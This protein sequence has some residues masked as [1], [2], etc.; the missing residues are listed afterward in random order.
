L[1]WFNFPYDPFFDKPLETDSEFKSL[2]VMTKGLKET[3]SGFVSQIHKIPHLCLIAGERGVGKST[4]MYYAGE[5]LRK[6]G[7]LSVYIG[8]HHTK[9]DA[10][11]KPVDEL[12]RD[13][14]EIISVETIRSLSSQFP[15]TFQ[16]NRRRYVDLMGFLGFTF[17]PSVGFLP[18]ITP[19]HLSYPDLEKH[20][21]ELIQFLNTH[22]GMRILLMIDNLDKVKKIESVQ[23][24]LGSAFGQTFF[25]HLRQ[26]GAS[27]MIAVGPRFLA[28]QKLDRDLNY[29]SRVIDIPCLIP[30]QAFNLIE[31]RITNCAAT[32]PENPFPKEALFEICLMKHGVTRDI[33]TESR[34]LCMSAGN[35]E[36]SQIDKKFVKSG[37]ISF[38]P[39]RVFYE[40]MDSSESIKNSILKLLGLQTVL[41]PDQLA[42]AGSALQSIAAGK[43]TKIPDRAHAALLDLGIILQKHGEKRKYTFNSE[44]ES[45]LKTCESKGWVRSDF[46]GWITTSEG[47]EVAII[48]TPG[49]RAFQTLEGFGPVTEPSRESVIINVSRIERTF[50]A[51]EMKRD[52]EIRLKLARKIMERVGKLSWDD[53]DCKTV[54]VD[55]YNSLVNFLVAYSKLYLASI[56]KSM[57]HVRSVRKFD[58]VRS[59]KSIIQ[60]ETGKMINSWHRVLS[61]R[62]NVLG[63][64]L[65]E[66]SPSHAELKTAFLDYEEVVKELSSLWQEILVTQETVAQPRDERMIKATDRLNNIASLLR[67]SFEKP[68]YLSVEKDEEE[69]LV[70]FQTFPTHKVSFDVVREKKIKDEEGSPCSSFFISCVHPVLRGRATTKDIIAFI[71]KCKYLTDLIESKEESVSNYWPRYYLAFVGLN[72]FDRGITAAIT[73]TDLPE[74]SKI[75]LLND[76]RLA[77][78]ETDLIA[79]AR[80][81][82]ASSEFEDLGSSLEDLLRIMIKASDVIREK[83]QK[84][85]TVMLADLKEFTQ[86]TE[87]DI[88]EAAVA[89]QRLSDMFDRNVL[90]Y[91]GKGTQTEGDAYVAAFD[92]AEDATNA[93][94]ST[95][96]ELYEYNKGVGTKKQILVRVG[97]NS[98]YA[99]FKKG[100]PFVGTVLNLAARAMRELGPGKICVTYYALKSMKS[101]KG[102]KFRSLG[103]KDLKGFPRPIDLYEAS[104]A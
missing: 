41:N 45:L 22:A 93:A 94:L 30:N 81:E 16:R 6:N 36:V 4:A 19:V 42:E 7:G 1:K 40:L 67:Y 69:Y 37:L 91:G 103:L 101:Q 46:L 59:T 2:L 63:I 68:E 15:E 24:F 25:H 20:I 95:L 17:E 3:I 51:S 76:R 80:T 38:N 85:C 75:T 56:S 28:V 97:I 78:F 32:P 79:T 60:S 98:G 66:R 87:E 58:L 52:A 9:V 88:L 10:S 65:G 73:A 11:N 71:A 70:G 49:L 31:K 77:D 29:L 53:I 14:L 44:I 89:V 27:T 57:P 82:I 84:T 54:Y 99:I 8:L 39:N 18:D 48:G 104:R 13:L 90:K 34:N 50:S 72:G 21:L 83:F 74:K 62:A 86:R 35:L 26:R 64:R 5:N 61:L 102:F 23:T 92:R 33:L 96:E 47:H 43:I 100:Q 12:K 55:L